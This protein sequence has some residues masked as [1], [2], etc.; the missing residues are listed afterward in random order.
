MA[1]SNKGLTNS[2][3][4]KEYTRLVNQLE[5]AYGILNVKAQ[6]FADA[7]NYTKENA[8]VRK[9]MNQLQGLIQ[10]QDSLRKAAESYIDTNKKNLRLNEDEAKALKKSI[11]D[12]QEYKKVVDEIVESKM[13]AAQQKMGAAVVKATGGQQALD[14]IDNRPGK[15]GFAAAEKKGRDSSRK[16]LVNKNGTIKEDEAIIAANLEYNRILK[17]TIQNGG[18]AEDAM[19]ELTKTM[20]AYKLELTNSYLQHRRR[21]E[22]TNN[23]KYN[24]MCTVSVKVNEALL[25]GMRPE[26]N[27]TAAIRKWAQQQID[28]RIQ[29]METE[30]GRNESQEDLWHAI[31]QDEDLLL[32]PSEIVDDGGEAIDLETFRAD[33]HRMIDE[34]YAEP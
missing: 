3:D 27:S 20:K 7:N 31:E 12:A 18:S 19:A 30:L 29:Q 24:N 9:Y 14:E 33:L 26:L 25:R 28:L 21:K 32:K 15:F 8:E 22:I 34:V 1:Q 4:I 10:K 11:A 5:K 6:G 13:K 2:N 23:I 17:E 16:A